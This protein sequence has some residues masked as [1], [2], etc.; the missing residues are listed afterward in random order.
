MGM[1]WGWKRFVGDGVGMEQISVPVSLS[2][3]W[4]AWERLTE[5]ISDQHCEG[6][7]KRLG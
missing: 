4:S 5:G 1:G 7:R 6:F 3:R 2:T